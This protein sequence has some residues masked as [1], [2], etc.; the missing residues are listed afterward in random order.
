MKKPIQEEIS[1]Y[2]IKHFTVKLADGDLMDFRRIYHQHF[3]QVLHFIRKFVAEKEEAEKI[4]T[5]IFIDF[6]EQS[7]SIDSRT[8]IESKLFTISKNMVKDKIRHNV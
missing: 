1:S 5:Q 3:S 8:S 7:D 2:E 4:V 6:W